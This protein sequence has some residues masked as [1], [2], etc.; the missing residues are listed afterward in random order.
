MD[1]IFPIDIKQETSDYESEIGLTT[2]TQIRKMYYCDK[3]DYSASKST[4]VKYHKQTVHE[5]L[6]Y[7]CDQCDYKA[8]ENGALKKHKQTQ[9]ENVDFWCH[10]CDHGASQRKN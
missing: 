10:L 6:R 9:H 4:S 1:G 3:C 8:T 7:A 2:P 5:G